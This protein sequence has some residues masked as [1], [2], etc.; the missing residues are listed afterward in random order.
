MEYRMTFPFRSV[1]Q[2]IRSWFTARKPRTHRHF[3]KL[4]VEH[5][6]HR[7]APAI[8]VAV[9]GTGGL[10]NDTGFQ[11]I[12]NQLNDDT[13]FDFS[14]ILVSASQVDSLAELNAYDVVVIGNNGSFTNGDPFDNAAFTSALRG[15]VETGGG[16]VATGWTVGGAGTTTG[17]PIADINAIIPV[18]TSG[19]QAFQGGGA[20]VSPNA[21]SHPVTAGVTPFTISSGNYVEFPGTAPLTDPGSTTLATTNAQPSV[22]VGNPGTGRAVY[23]GPIY[24]GVATFYNNAELRTG[25]ADRLLEQ[26]VAWAANSTT[27]TG[28]ELVTNGGFETGGFAG[29]TISNTGSGAWVINNGSGDPLGP[30]GPLPPITGSYDAVAVQSGP[31]LLVLSN[32]I[33]VPAGVSSATFSWSDRILNWAPNFSD[34]NQ[35]WRVRILDAGGGLIQQVYSTNPGDVLQQFG[36]NQR[37][38]NVTSL[39]QSLAGQTIRLSFELESNLGYFNVALDNV[40]LRVTTSTQTARQL[41]MVADISTRSVTV[42]D[43]VTNTALGSLIIPNAGAG[44]G[45]VAVV[46]NLGFVTDFASRIFVID[47]SNPATPTLASGINVI[48]ISN[49]GQDIT[50][51]PD[52]KYLVISNGSFVAPLAV[53]DIA[54][55]TQIGTF[56]LGTDFNSVEAASNGSVLATSFNADTLHR[57]TI[58]SLGALTNT[59]EVLSISNPNNV[60]AAPTGSTGVVLSRDAFM[61]SFRTSGLV[62]VTSRTLDSLP[63]SGVFHPAGDRFYVRTAAFLVAFGFNQTTGELSTSPLFFVSIPGAPGFFAIEQLTISPDGTRLYLPSDATNSVRVYNA[64]TGAFI[65]EIFGS[66]FQVPTGIAIG[67]S[68]ANQP[69]T[70]PVDTNGAANTVA[71]GALNGTPVGVTVLAS[72]PGQ[73]VTYS[74]TNNAGGR[75]AI[76]S[77]N[78]VITVANS[79]LLDGP[80]SHVITVLASDGV[81]GTSSA[82]FTINVTSVAP[83]ATISHNGPVSYGESFTVSLTNPSDPSAADTSAGF[84]Y[85]FSLTGDF[86]GVT[87]ATQTSVA[88]QTFTRN[89]GTYTVYA[90]I[91][92]KDNHFTQYSTTVTVNPAEISYDIGDATHVYGSTVD[93]AA[94]LG[95][96]FHTGVNGEN[97]SIVYSSLGNTVLASAG[98]YDITGI[99]SDGT[100]LASNYL[101]T[102]I[103]GTLTVTKATLTGQAST[104]DA[105]NMAKQGK[106]IITISNLDGFLNGDSLADFL[107]TAR[108]YLT[109]GANKYEFVPTA[110]VAVDG[111]LILTYSLKNSSL[112]QQMGDAL[113]GANSGANAIEAGLFMESTNYTFAIDNMTRLFSTVR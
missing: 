31:S 88:S 3:S 32:P 55:R 100:G 19:A 71:E 101:V 98:T 47:L 29:W 72:D 4:S 11:A 44:M 28:T 39:L 84:R 6:E 82:N 46:G 52:L 63:I 33:V 8:N 40:S 111:S 107:S 93:L 79:A 67:L 7:L 49:N 35:E 53:V 36:P 99:V 78:G 65:T 45:D 113:A 18:N 12:V 22:V 83:I 26:A 94:V 70:T 89:A 20:T 34:P 109:I 95:T 10:S 64:E 5:L 110:T 21:T 76:N 60:Y 87:Y 91:I 23:L 104:Q 48:P 17:T 86:T 51:T 73:T 69:P 74:L 37:S 16:V 38:F 43:P 80:T 56:S 54:T 77:S 97:L 108:F 15:W 90:R 102:L 25:S 68:F 75:F 13:H 92:D 66:N 1:S 30:T 112:L 106:L 14:A 96:T 2:R 61:T 57:F 62:P 9:V 58:N 24:S 42:F 81:G 41:G 50:V 103:P 59:G 105:L 85:A 27:P